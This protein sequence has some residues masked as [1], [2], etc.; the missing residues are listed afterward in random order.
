MLI[1]I[2]QDKM[3]QSIALL[4]QKGGNGDNI[5]AEC[6]VK[7]GSFGNRNFLQV[8][9]VGIKIGMILVFVDF[10]GQY[11]SGQLR[12]VLPENGY[13]SMFIM[14]PDFF[15]DIGKGCS[16]KETLVCVVYNFV[17]YSGAKQNDKQGADQKGSEQR[18]EKQNMY[19]CMAAWLAFHGFFLS[20]MVTVG[21][22]LE[23]MFS[24]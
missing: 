23:P 24:Y 19:G 6:R 20:I 21:I 1:V 3:I 13:T 5:V 17:I 9:V 18:Y 22:I 2:R 14:L 4:H 11:K 10:L 8:P 7:G 15:G 16:G 12:V